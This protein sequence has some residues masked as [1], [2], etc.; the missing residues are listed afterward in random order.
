[1]K[2]I[3]I[4]IDKQIAIIDSVKKEENNSLALFFDVKYIKENKDEVR[5]IL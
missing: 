1:M 4:L 2:L 3:R 5:K